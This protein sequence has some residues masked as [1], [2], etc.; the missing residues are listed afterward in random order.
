MFSPAFAVFNFLGIVFV[1]LPAAWHWTA[2]NTA[3]LLFI[4]WCMVTTVPMAINS[5]VWYDGVDIR[6]PVYCDIITKLRI[7]GDVGIPAA[8]LCITRQLEAIAAAR[9]A[10][11]SAKDRYQRRII[12]LSIGLGLPI[13]VMIM[14]TVVQ[15]HRYDIIQRVGCIPAVYWSLPAVF[16]VIIWPV[17]LLLAA[18]VY[19]GLAVR[20][21]IARR[22]Q[23][24]RL[25]ESSKSAISTNRFIRL[26]ALSVT[27]IT[28]SLPVALCVRVIQFATIPLNPYISWGN[29]H[30]GFNYVGTVTLKQFELG[31]K[32]Y[33]RLQE[34]NYWQYAFSCTLFFLF[35]GLGEESLASYR[36]W[37][38]AVLRLVRRRQAS[39]DH[40][41]PLPSAT[42]ISLPPY[43]RT[44]SAAM[45][46][47]EKREFASTGGVFVTI[48]ENDYASV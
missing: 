20:L 30:Y 28:Y 37:G 12:D 5:I 17:I 44:E 33:L 26:I 6:A 45:E 34:L 10:Q 8:T 18:A 35:F 1:L 46:E 47:R 40:K 36:R 24:A 42:S 41:S 11:F 13:L 3:T 15:G 4:F 25:L 38:L 9:Q 48:E 29:V 21:F 31:S 16:L 14:H 32:S 2:R 22:Y 39:E 43:L 27:Q 7:G 19:A 23:F